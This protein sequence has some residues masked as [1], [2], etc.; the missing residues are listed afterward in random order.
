ML[1]ELCTELY[2]KKSDCLCDEGLSMAGLGPLHEHCK[3]LIDKLLNSI[4]CNPLHK[5]Y[6]FTFF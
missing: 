5:L 1:I 4:L 2:D 6:S 3:L